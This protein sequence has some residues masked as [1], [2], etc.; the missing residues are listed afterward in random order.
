V[1]PPP[2][3]V[4]G[5]NSVENAEVMVREDSMLF[6]MAFEILLK[7]RNDNVGFR[8][9]RQRQFKSSYKFS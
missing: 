7:Q 3:R 4:C 8:S 1:L 5:F 9:M 2:D 6:S